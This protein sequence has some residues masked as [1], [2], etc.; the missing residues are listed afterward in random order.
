[1]TT[2]RKGPRPLPLHLMAAAGISTSSS[3]AWT[4]LKSG[5]EPWSEN[6]AEAGRELQKDLENVQPEAFSS[7]L[8]GELYDQHLDF[9]N[10]LTTYR[11]HPYR[12]SLTMPPALWESGAARL[13]D[14]G[15]TDPAGELG[16]PVLVVPSL[17]NRG[18]ILDLL[19]N[20]SFLRFMA[21][22]GIRPLLLDWGS[23]GKEDLG[24]SL[25]DYISGTL[26]DALEVTVEVAGGAPVPVLGYCM[27][28]TLAAALSVLRPEC[29]SALALLAA[30]WD[31]H[32]GTG[33]PPPAIV[34]G[35]PALDG[36]IDTL[37]HLPVDAIQAMFFSLDPLL[38]WNK[39]RSFAT[40]DPAGNQARTFVALE[41][42]LN[43]GVPLSGPVARACLFGWY[44][45]NQPASGRWQVAGTVIDPAAIA[46][47]TLGVIPATDR[48]VPP[49]SA[50]ALVSAIPGAEL[51]SPQAG[52]I[53][54]IIGRSAEK[55]LW[56][57]LVDWL[58]N[59]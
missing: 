41:D 22:R 56:I 21:T 7:A 29:V 1:M 5:W 11:S 34:A 55:K 20:C 47:P 10:G 39:F 52:H 44:I 4:L 8:Q 48:I 46:C 12:R 24:R 13:L 40:L 9:L 15:V 31:F 50:G 28:G 54:M 17:V 3:T 57:P 23:P 36:M 14:Y 19:E 35:Q 26:S 18:Y 53:G 43:D 38:G 16:R 49:A 51:L 30:P 25:D 45:D 33:G 58:H 2:V 27:G 6:L 37:G 32:A 42:W 59:N